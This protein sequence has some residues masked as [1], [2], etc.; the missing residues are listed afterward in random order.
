MNIDWDILETK[1]KQAFTQIVDDFKEDQIQEL[2]SEKWDWPR[3][4]KRQNHQI[5]GS[6]RDIVDLGELKD[7]LAIEP[8]T[9]TEVVYSYPVEYAMI[10]HQGATL[11]TGTEL[12]ARPWVDA[13]VEEL[14]Q[15]F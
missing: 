11:H 2:E 6:P 7:S 3:N 5:V 8:I 4:T 12:P 14:K 10:V 1:I 9:S 13:A 15:N